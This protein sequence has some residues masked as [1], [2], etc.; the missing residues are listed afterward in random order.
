MGIG[1]CLEKQSVDQ[2][3]SNGVDLHDEGKRNPPRFHRRA[4]WH[5]HRPGLAVMVA[6]FSVLFSCAQKLD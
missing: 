3:N 6:G 4:L 1:F 2:S 5:S